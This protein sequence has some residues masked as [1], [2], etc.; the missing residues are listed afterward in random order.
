MI[1]FF[2]RLICVLAILLTSACGSAS[3]SIGGGNGTTAPPSTYAS[4]AVNAYPCDPNTGTFQFSQGSLRYSLEAQHQFDLGM[5]SHGY[6]NVVYQTDSQVTADSVTGSFGQADLLFFSGHGQPGGIQ[7]S[8]LFCGG[9]PASIQAWGVGSI[10]GT[11]PQFFLNPIAPA[12]QV[13]GRMKWMIFDSS[14]SVAGPPSAERN[15]VADPIYDANWSQVFGGS[16]HGI[17]GYWQSPGYCLGD[18]IS[19]ARTCDIIDDQYQEGR[20]ATS[21]TNNAF[22][23]GKSVH[24]AWYQAAIDANR[25]EQWAIWETSS[26]RQDSL[27]SGTN[28]GPSGSVLFYYSNAP[29]GIATSA[30][31][32]KPDV[33]TVQPFS[34]NNEPINDA[35]AIQQA[36]SYVGALDAQSDN[37]AQVVIKKGS[38]DATHYYGTSGAVV[39]HGQ[40]QQYIVNQATA[41]NAAV[42]FVTSTFGMPSDAVLTSQ[43]GFYSLDPSTKS[44]TATNW[45]FI[46]HHSNGLV[47]G[48]AIKVVVDATRSSTTVCTQYST[49]YDQIGRPHSI[50]V[51]RQ[52]TYAYQPNISYGFRQWRSLS[53]TRHILSN[54]QPANSQTSIDARTASAS[55]PPGVGHAVS[56]YSSGFWSDGQEVP[57]ATN[58]AVPAWLF[59]AGGR[60]FGV[61]AV[62]G[63]L[64]GSA[65]V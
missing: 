2:K 43:R 31:T 17:Y 56:S 62:T 46:W 24:D 48:D 41:Q 5:N 3:W 59:V 28:Y 6:S 10:Y 52:T 13:N 29:G 23:Q 44:Q 39:M 36:S 65:P 64:L 1:A 7:F 42:A 4:L 58:G 12:S 11:P 51:A 55:L 40:P 54:G 32:V 20:T 38:T 16:L 8:Q 26:N 57:S 63:Q 22:N 49:W 25:D 9:A 19:P 35:S 61:D 45:E 33:F 27:T 60:Y 14:T 47:G 18:A 21:F 50:C 34:L 15:G 37:G 30:I 53:G